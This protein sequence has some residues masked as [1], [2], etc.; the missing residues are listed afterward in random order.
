MV[1]QAGPG[2][3]VSLGAPLPAAGGTASFVASAW[4]SP[5]PAQQQ[6]LGGR[7]CGKEEDQSLFAVECWVSYFTSWASIFAPPPAP[8]WQAISLM[9][10]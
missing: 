5:C 2:P 4:M 1:S 3:S 9:E 8:K 7:G 10:A 6:G